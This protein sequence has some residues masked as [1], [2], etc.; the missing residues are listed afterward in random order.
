MKP[1]ERQFQ[2]KLSE[3]EL[4]NSRRTLKTLS[5]IDFS[6]ND[7]LGYARS[8]FLLEKFKRKILSLEQMGS[9][10]SRLLSGNHPRHLAVEEKIA[11]IF[12]AQSALLFSS[13]YLANL[14]L[15]QALAPDRTIIM[16]ELCHN[17]MINGV[18][19]SGSKTLFFRHNDLAHLEKRLQNNK[20]QSPLI[21]IEAVYSMDGDLAPLEEIVTLAEKYGAEIIIDEAHSSGVIGNKG[22]GLTSEFE[23][24]EKI[25]ARVITLGKAFG[26]E[27]AVVLGSKDLKDYLINFCQSFIYTT[28]VS[29]PN[30]MAIETSLEHFS[31]SV[32]E[33]EK[34]H[35]NLKYFSEQTHHH[36][37]SPIFPWKIGGNEHTKTIAI[38]LQ[39]EGMNVFPILSPTVKRSDERIR[40]VFHAFNTKEEIDRLVLLMSKY[41]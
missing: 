27:G 20:D 5:G 41:A 28:A 12:R 35:Q 25:L 34:L 22:L 11:Q 36:V 21:L 30:L 6:S 29:M 10:G 38:H 23:L 13:G 32:V 3:R 18:K 40:I 16:D 14:G 26:T 4:K 31:S 39:S 7:Y 8:P 33:V 2:Q 1:S 15:I 37:V 19:L 17:S 24:E 9:T